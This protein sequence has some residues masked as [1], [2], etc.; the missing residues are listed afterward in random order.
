[1]VSGTLALLKYSV[2]YMD[3]RQDS[4]PNR[5]Q[6]PVEWGVVPSVH[7]FVL[8]SPPEARAR[9]GE[10]QARYWEA[11]ARPLKAKFRT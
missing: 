6:S 11:L 7:S 3:L 5:G 4:G 10:A 2:N 9:T 8:P 1:M